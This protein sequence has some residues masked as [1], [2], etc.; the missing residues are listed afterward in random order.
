MSAQ[1]RGITTVLAS[2]LS[3][4]LHSNLT[5]GCVA[6][7][8]TCTT[9]QRLASYADMLLMGNLAHD[10]ISLSWALKANLRAFLL[11]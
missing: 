11:A 10:F 8:F 9:D 1:K 3:K 7:R 4:Q 5:P 2:D 6:K